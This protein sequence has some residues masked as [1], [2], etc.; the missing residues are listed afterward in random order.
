MAERS[1]TRGPDRDVHGTHG[2]SALTVK[3]DRGAT[4]MREI[5]PFPT[6]PRS[7]GTPSQAVFD[8]DMAGIYFPTAH[9]PGEGTGHPDRESEMKPRGSV[10]ARCRLG[11]IRWIISGVR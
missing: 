6:G 4:V 9:T 3:G 1:G 5:V 11:K 7:H 2:I 10:Q 8:P